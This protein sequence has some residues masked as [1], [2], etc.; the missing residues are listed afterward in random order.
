MYLVPLHNPNRMQPDP[1]SWLVTALVDELETLAIEC[2]EAAADHG[3]GEATERSLESVRSLDQ[4]AD[5]CVE[6]IQLIRREYQ[7]GLTVPRQAPP[8]DPEPPDG[9]SRRARRPPAA[10]LSPGRASSGAE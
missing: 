4:A 9:A 7:R 5:T 10:G 1:T 8:H 6:I 2:R 3:G